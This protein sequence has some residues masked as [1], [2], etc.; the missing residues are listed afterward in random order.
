MGKLSEPTRQA[1]A[2]AQR[3]LADRRVLAE[4]AVAA[5]QAD[6]AGRGLDAMTLEQVNAV[7]E[8]TRKRL[9]LHAA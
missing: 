2:A 7:I 1:L 4:R 3:D 8:E 6:A 5:I 9:K